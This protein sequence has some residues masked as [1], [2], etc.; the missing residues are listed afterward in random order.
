MY[1]SF[2]FEA[3]FF[4]PDRE[5]IDFVADP[6]FLV[7]FTPHDPFSVTDSKCIWTF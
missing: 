5:I 3:K 1:F 2:C 7:S 6:R 4:E